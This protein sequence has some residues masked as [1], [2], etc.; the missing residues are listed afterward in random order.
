MIV[1]LYL[2]FSLNIKENSAIVL[3]TKEK[4]TLIF[5]VS[6]CKLRAG[7]SRVESYS[8]TLSPVYIGNKKY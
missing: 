6:T 5:S 2:N 8:N 3:N 4:L 1:F 7:P